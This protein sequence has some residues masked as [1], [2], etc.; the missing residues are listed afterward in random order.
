MSNR[1]D[2]LIYTFVGITID[3][4]GIDNVLW[5]WRRMMA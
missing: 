3:L 1:P 5:Q 4:I 2:P